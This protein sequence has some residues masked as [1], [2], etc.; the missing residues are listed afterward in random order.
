MKTLVFAGKFNPTGL[1]D[2]IAQTNHN[3]KMRNI[4]P[5]WARWSFSYKMHPSGNWAEEVT[6]QVPDGLDTSK[7]ENEVSKHKWQDKDATTIANETFVSNYNSG[8]QKIK[9]L[10]LT[11]D[12][13]LAI[14]GGRTDDF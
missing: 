5:W 12:E 6:M 1:F 2:K 14:C 10:G 13:F 3:L 7:I 4:E 8:K 11:E 9:A